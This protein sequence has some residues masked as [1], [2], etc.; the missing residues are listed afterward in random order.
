[1]IFFHVVHTVEASGA[2]NIREGI[3]GAVAGPGARIETVTVGN[4]SQPPSKDEGTWFT[5]TLPTHVQTCSFTRWI[6]V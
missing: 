5:L 6:S 4:Q 2:V 1:M 3:V